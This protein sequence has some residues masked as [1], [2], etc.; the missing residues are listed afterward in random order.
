AVRVLVRRRHRPGD[1]R[2]GAP[3]RHDQGHPGQPFA[4]LRAGAR[5][6]AQ[7]RPAGDAGRR[8]RVAVRAMSAAA[9]AQPAGEPRFAGNDRLLVGMILGVLTFWLFAQSTLNIAPDM[10]RDP[11][12]GAGTMTGAVAAAALF[13]GI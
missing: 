2:G 3:G 4:A 11:G 9:G 13:S 1:V 12:I 6:D 7:D 10:Q 8:V 5:S